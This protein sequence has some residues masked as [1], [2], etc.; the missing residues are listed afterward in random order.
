M[1]RSFT[2]HNSGTADLILGPL[3]LSGPAAF[4]FS[5]PPAPA[6]PVAAGGS[7]SFQVS[8][9]PSASGLRSA[10]LSWATNDFYN[11]T[12][13]FAIQGTGVSSTG[14]DAGDGVPNLLEFA[15]GTNS[16]GPNSGPGPLRYS[17]TF[18]GAGT[19]TWSSI[20]SRDLPFA[21]RI[22]ALNLKICGAFVRSG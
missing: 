17:G 13:N 12:F 19:S 2:I 4:D 18:G 15:C 3:T 11:R 14:D 8:F 16:A 21:C 1:T 22:Q 5:I 9:A 20:R 10:T 7:S 6:S